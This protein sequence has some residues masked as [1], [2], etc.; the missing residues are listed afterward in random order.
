MPT[1]GPAPEA[2]TG[3]AGE[4]TRRWAYEV[5]DALRSE[6]ETPLKVRLCGRATFADVLC[7]TGHCTGDG[8]VRASLDGLQ[9]CKSVWECP[10][11]AR[12]ILGERAAILTRALHDY[13]KE[14]L[15]TGRLIT[16]GVY[17]LTLTVRHAKGNDLEELRRALTKAYRFCIQGSSWVGMQEEL[18][19]DIE[20]MRRVEVT[21]GDVH[22]F[23]PHLHIVVVMP[24]VLTEL[25]LAA[26]WSY[27]AARW[28]VAIERFLGPENV[29][30][31]RQ[32]EPLRSPGVDLR[33]SSNERYIAKMGLE[34][35]AWKSKQGYVDEEGARHRQVWEIAND[36]AEEG[37]DRDWQLWRAYCRSM[38]GARMHAWSDGFRAR[39][40]RLELELALIQEL[41]W[42]GRSQLGEVSIDEWELI[43]EVRLAVP[44]LLEA[45]ELG[46]ELAM[47]ALVLELIAQVNAEWREWK[48]ARD[49]S[50]A[51]AGPPPLPP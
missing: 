33:E 8:S 11:C 45:A 51:G 4:D 18:G 20:T 5:H 2:K 13:R 10:R 3:G 27:W 15:P 34:L 23:H 35:T 16:R 37:Y 50:V 7:I 32:R 48:E 40:R 6:L 30:D 22:G 47:R 41:C 43:R 24:R 38:K 9:S 49:G 17:L 26:F 12:R 31:V 19:G 46:G 25:E 36:W 39:W 29:P 14:R 42:H 21:H 1:G 28:P 44:K